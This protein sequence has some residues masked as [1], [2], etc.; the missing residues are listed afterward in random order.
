M[1]FIKVNYDYDDNPDKVIYKGISLEINPLKIKTWDTGDFVKDWYMLNQYIY[2]ETELWKSPVSVS[3]S[4]NHFIMDTNKYSSK[5]LVTTDDG[6]GYIFTKDYDKSGLEF[7]INKGTDP[8][9]D[10][11]KNYAGSK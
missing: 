2:M 7:F 9:W 1:S 8:T 6:Y 3:S 10:E 4:L 5:W 11:H